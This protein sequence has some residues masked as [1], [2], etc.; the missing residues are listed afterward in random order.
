MMFR[1]SVVRPLASLGLAAALFAGCSTTLILDN[2]R[3]QQ[4]ITSGL[5][6]NGITAQ[7]TCYGEIPIRQ[8]DVSSCKATTPDGAILTIQVT[9]TDDKGTVNWQ[10]VGH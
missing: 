4:E 9:Q 7:V 1:T 8:D 2:A 3:L 6:D 10:L 5:A